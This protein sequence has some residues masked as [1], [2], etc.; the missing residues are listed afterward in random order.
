MAQIVRGRIL[1]SSLCLAV[2]SLA[3]PGC[4]CEDRFR[5]QQ[6]F[7]PRHAT[8]PVGGT[9]QRR[10]CSAEPST[11]ASRSQTLRL[12]R[13]EVFTPD[14]R[15]RPAHRRTGIDSCR[16]RPTS[17]CEA[18]SRVTPD[19]RVVLSV[20]ETGRDPRPGDRRPG[21]PGFSAPRTADAP[22]QARE[23][24]GRLRARRGRRGASAAT[25]TI[26]E[27]RP[28]APATATEDADLAAFLET[29][30]VAPKDSGG[31]ERWSSTTRR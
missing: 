3:G 7:S 31:G 5:S 19:S 17:I 2:F 29:S 22:L 4:R 24:D 8:L 11:A 21:G 1:L 6:R 23:V 20:L 12:E 18:G 26:S 14:A 30:A 27:R 16:S 9:L 10:Q 15:A 28:S 25:S 13:F